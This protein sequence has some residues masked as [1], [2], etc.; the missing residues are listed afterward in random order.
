M[1]SHFFG[2]GKYSGSDPPLDGSETNPGV[3]GFPTCQYHFFYEWWAIFEV[4][5]VVCTG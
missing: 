4:C 3:A 2:L 5:G 1:F